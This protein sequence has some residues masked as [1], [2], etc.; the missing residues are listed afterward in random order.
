MYDTSASE[1][2]RSIL[3]LAIILTFNSCQLKLL[4]LVRI[5]VDHSLRLPILVCCKDAACQCLSICK[6][7]RSYKL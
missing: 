6:H 5:S 7:V 4:D 1:H 3:Q 2:T